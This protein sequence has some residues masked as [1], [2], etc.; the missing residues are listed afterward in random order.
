MDRNQNKI[1]DFLMILIWLCRFKILLKRVNLRV[2]ETLKGV[3]QVR[4]YIYILH[5]LPYNSV[6]YLTIIHIDILLISTTSPIS[7]IVWIDIL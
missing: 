4:I 5:Q 6:M 2:S 7:L 3:W 1:I